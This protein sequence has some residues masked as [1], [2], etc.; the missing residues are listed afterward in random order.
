MDLKVFEVIPSACVYGGDALARL[1]DGRA[2]FIPFVLPG[3]TCRI[4][5]VEEKEHYARAELLEVVSPS[6]LRITPRCLHF[7]DCGG[8]HY[9]HINYLEQLNIKRD[10][11]KDQLERVGK[12][13]NPPVRDAIASPEQ[14][15]YRN[16][17]QF[18]ISESG[19]PGFSR[20][21]SHTIV[22]IKE[23]HLPEDSINQ[24]W[25]ALDL[26]Y[27]PG[28][29]RI[30]LRA[31]EEGQ[32]ILIVLETSDPKPIEFTVDLPLSAVLQGPGGE[33]ILSGDE[34]TIIP[35][36]DF[37]FVVSAGS[38]F[39]V[40][41][42]MAEILIDHLLDILPLNKDTVLL[43]VYCGVGLFSVFLAPLVKELI[44]IESHPAAGE[45]FLYNLSGLNNV[46]LYDASAEDVLSNLDIDPDV[47]LLDPPRA[48]ISVSVLDRVVSLSPDMIVYISCDPAT[49]ARDAAR[50]L[51]QGYM[52][53]DSTPF[54][55]FPQTYHIESL[56]IFRRES[57]QA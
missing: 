42:R 39:Q 8:C 23:C 51:K 6:P 19:Q 34:F 47:I 20:H 45:D 54:D 3:E 43:D 41:A 49:L 14:W 4:R 36:H 9:Q 33:I 16:H 55:M 27:N 37:P 5:L 46:K 2:V 11:L 17:I 40:N 10:I 52:L 56:N 18:R 1:P 57:S 29:D 32:D 24:I 48:G 30:S 38:F 26:E 12:F 31:G 35:V 28:L 15:N 22:P 25:P 50:F 21:R 7:K 13:T 53:M 44:G